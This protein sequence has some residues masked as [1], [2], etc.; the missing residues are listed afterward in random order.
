MGGK[1]RKSRADYIE[2]YDILVLLVKDNLKWFG[3]RGIRRLKG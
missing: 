3:W 2:Y 1:A